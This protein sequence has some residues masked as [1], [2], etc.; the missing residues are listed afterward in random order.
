[1][2]QLL[3]EAATAPGRVARVHQVDLCGE[4]RLDVREYELG[5]RGDPSPLRGFSLRV[6]ALPA[7]IAALQDAE[8][9][10]QNRGLFPADAEPKAA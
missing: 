10:L 7:L 5:A 4:Q 8:R 1:M 6:D 9:E 3:A 2:A